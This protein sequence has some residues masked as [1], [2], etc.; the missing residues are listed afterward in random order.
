MEIRYTKVSQDQH[1]IKIIRADQSTDEAVQE[2]RSYL[3]HDFAHFAVEIEI[4]LR[5]GYWG[6]VAAGA[7]LNGMSIRGQDI[8]IA[9]SL[10]GPVQGLVRDEK[11]RI[12]AYMAVLETMQPQLA[13]QDLAAR[14]HEQ[15]RKLRGHWKATPYGSDMVFEWPENL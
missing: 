5:G 10:A 7:K 14:I 15:V 4:P 8:V 2:S 9:E 3:R 11:S 13:T 12:Q 1:T 6:S